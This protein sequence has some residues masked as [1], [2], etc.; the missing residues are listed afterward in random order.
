MPAKKC[1]SNTKSR[2]SVKT[3]KKSTRTS[4]I[5]RHMTKAAQPNIARK[6]VQGWRL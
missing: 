6:M 3:A 2:K 1:R 4:H 5:V